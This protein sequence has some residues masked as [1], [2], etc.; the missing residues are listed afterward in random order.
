MSKF[1]NHPVQVELD[2]EDIWTIL[3]LFRDGELA[4]LSP[5]LEQRFV[6]GYHMACIR[7]AKIKKAE[8]HDNE[9]I[10][11]E[12][13]LEVA[14][15]SC[16]PEGAIN[17]AWLE[18]LNHINQTETIKY[19][20]PISYPAFVEVLEIFA[21]YVDKQDRPAVLA[22]G[23]C[24]KLSKFDWQEQNFNQG[25]EELQEIKAELEAN[26]EELPKPYRVD[27][28]DLSIKALCQIRDEFEQG[29]EPPSAGN[30]APPPSS[31]ILLD[32]GAEAAF[33]AIKNA[34]NDLHSVHKREFQVVQEH[35]E[36]EYPLGES[37]AE[38]KMQATCSMLEILDNIEEKFKLK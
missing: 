35:N 15:S 7:E 24:L 18:Y 38:G 37:L 22:G 36:L 19:Y 1:H 16:L 21:E 3:K 5:E 13:A 25:I 28:V 27:A 26:E 31:V 10:P 12:E 23:A 6:I 9:P 32:Q 20:E 11:I 33:R 17:A 29:N 30:D 4:V 2:S 34:M 14:E 8:E